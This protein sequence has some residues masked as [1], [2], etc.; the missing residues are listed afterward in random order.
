MNNDFD[1][2][3]RLN[4]I[5]W[6]LGCY[7]RIEVKLSEYSL[8]RKIPMEL[9][10]LDVLGIRILPDLSTDYLVAD[11]TLNKDVI[12]SPIQ[13]VF[14]LK[15][16]MNFFGASKGYLGLGTNNPI[17]ETQRIAAQRLGVTILNENNLAN[18]EKRVINSGLQL[19]LSEPESWLNFENKIASLSKNM[20]PLL[21]FRKY[22]Y[23]L[24]PSY[25]N[26]HALIFLVTRHNKFFDETNRLQKA[27]VL[28]LLT[29]L[30]L[31][32]LKMSE[33]VLRINPEN[34]ETELKA[35]LYGGY[36]EMK[37]RQSIVENI[38]KIMEKSNLTQ[39]SLFNETFKLDP[40]YLPQL[41]DIA[42][43]LLNKPFDSSQIL[44]YLQVI[45]FEKILDKGENAEG[46]KYLETGFPDITKK[47][48]RD[49]AKFFC[50][51][52]GISEKLVEDLY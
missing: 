4:N 49:I 22:H 19:K 7:T 2:K 27:L 32:V 33:Y 42:F 20:C 35:Y 47:L 13:R 14:W 18:L 30:T 3:I 9:T 45:L 17:S 41:F 6:S 5:F 46:M 23:W 8:Q 43:R 39:G 36:A 28:D 51:S 44:R 25:Q 31:S 29:L 34:P 37:R 24:N 10:D 16:V 26:I 38:R 12:K 48:T 1:L 21:N 40:D 50:D 11:C 15:G 52:T